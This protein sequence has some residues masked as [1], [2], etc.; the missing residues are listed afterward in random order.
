MAWTLDD[1]AKLDMR[2]WT[3]WGVFRSGIQYTVLDAGRGIQVEVEISRNHVELSWGR[4]SSQVIELERTPCN[5]GGRRVWFLC[6]RC[7]RRMQVL[8]L[9]LGY[10]MCWRCTRLIYGSQAES[11]LYRMMRRAQKLRRKLGGPTSLLYPFPQRP[12]RMRW[13][14]YVRLRREGE[15]LEARISEG[16]RAF[17]DKQRAFLEDMSRKVSHMLKDSESS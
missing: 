1:C 9:K 3:R 17:A 16:I 12:G 13:T 4:S 11:Q 14:T 6:P 10:W 8:Y 15:E 7:G 5:F 2:D